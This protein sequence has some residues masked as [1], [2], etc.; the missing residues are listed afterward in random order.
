MTYFSFDDLVKALKNKGAELIDPIPGCP[1]HLN[2][3]CMGMAGKC[4]LGNKR[5]CIQFMRFMHDKRFFT[6]QVLFSFYENSKTGFVRTEDL[7]ITAI[8][9]GGILCLEELVEL[10]K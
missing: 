4:H 1:M 9:K 5:Q 3:V 6:V 2:Y 8:L 10:S 7:G